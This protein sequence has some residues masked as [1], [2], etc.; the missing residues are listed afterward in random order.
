MRA[1]TG[2]AAAGILWAG[3]ASAVTDY[4][5][6][7]ALVAADP[8][9]AEI[10]AG[11]WARF[12]G[13]G[14][15]ARHCYALALI[16]TGAPSRAID[17]L[18]GIAMEEPDLGDPE[19]ADIL[20]Q[21]GNLLMQEGDAVTANVVA[22]QALRLDAANPAALA[23]RA[24]LKLEAGE[25]RAAIRDLNAALQ[26]RP[27]A[28]DFLLLRA[29]AYRQLGQYVQARD[30]ASFASENAPEDA[31]VWL[32]RGLAEA[33]LDDRP[34]ARKSFLEAISLDREGLI[35]KSAQR[36]LQRMDAGISD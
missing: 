7:V 35:G 15:P 12:G 11:D 31:E 34:A 20:G 14:A 2:L 6:C 27:A 29:S 22:G 24:R 17:E 1:L 25:P 18:I 4:D 28:V 10:E 13:G 33:G 3:Q 26:G 19:R 30:D 16:E 5:A 8:R 23:L 21:A 36:A 9:Q 32:E